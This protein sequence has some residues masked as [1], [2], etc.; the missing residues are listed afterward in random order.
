MKHTRPYIILF[1]LVCAVGLFAS[2]T[3]SNL[4]KIDKNTKIEGW[5]Y[6]RGDFWP[7]W[8]EKYD[9]GKRAFWWDSAFIADVEVHSLLIWSNDTTDTASLTPTCL[10]IDTVRAAIL[11]DTV[12]TDSVVSGNTQDTLT[13]SSFG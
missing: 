2:V 11:L 10:T 12:Y 8:S 1:I 4:H 7:L 3:S 9:I 6:I 5:L 13:N